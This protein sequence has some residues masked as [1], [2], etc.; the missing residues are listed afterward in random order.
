MSKRSGN[1]TSAA[2]RDAAELSVSSRGRLARILG[3]SERTL[4]TRLTEGLR[5]AC[6]DAEV[7]Q[8][9]LPD[10]IA[11]M[12]E[13]VWVQKTSEAKERLDRAKIDAAI[14]KANAD[15]EAAELRTAERAERV[16]DRDAT[17]NFMRRAFATVRGR[18]ESLPAECAMLFPSDIRAASVAELQARVR[19]ILR[20]LATIDPAEVDFAEGSE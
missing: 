18:F 17:V 15:A 7:K 20:G 9:R 10:A 3:I 16:V 4:T 13:T 2:A 14:R 5:D 19:G 12:R 1:Q 8:Y 11:W 6:Y